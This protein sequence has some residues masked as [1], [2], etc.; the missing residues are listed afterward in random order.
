MLLF[1]T[2]SSGDTVAVN[3]D[4]VSTIKF[5]KSTEYIFSSWLPDKQGGFVDAPTN[6]QSEIFFRDK[7]KKPMRV[8]ESVAQ[9]RVQVEEQSA[10]KGGA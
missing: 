4:D 8:A 10:T 1:L 2:D 6:A 5:C 9:I 3:V 7:T